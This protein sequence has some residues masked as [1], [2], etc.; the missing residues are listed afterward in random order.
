MPLL[1]W[2]Q[3]L[4]VGG[5]GAGVS[6]AGPKDEDGG[7][8]DGDG[9]EYHLPYGEMIE[10]GWKTHSGGSDVEEGARMDFMGP[11]PAGYDFPL[12]DASP[13]SMT[14]PF[15]YDFPDAEVIPTDPALRIRKKRVD[16]RVKRR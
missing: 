2:K 13:Q 12:S 14:V 11:L 6:V 16:L 8:D 3:A 9:S 1:H 7:R 15:C 10:S 4:S 5:A